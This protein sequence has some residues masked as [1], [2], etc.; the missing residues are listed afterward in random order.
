MSR[1]NDFI[2]VKDNKTTRISCDVCLQPNVID[3][4]SIENEDRGLFGEDIIC[5]SCVEKMAKELG[6]IK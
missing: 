1:Y 2:A 5:S 6:I 4:I 3:F